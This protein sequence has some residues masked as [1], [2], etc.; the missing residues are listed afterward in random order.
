MSVWVSSSKDVLAHVADREWVGV[1]GLRHMAAGQTP[2][3]EH[4]ADIEAWNQARYDVRR[5]QPWEE[6]WVDLRRAR[7]GA[8][9]SRSRGHWLM[10]N[11]GPS[12]CRA[13]VSFTSCRSVASNGT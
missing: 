12:C 5:D 10:A 8:R 7:R 6:V 11:G 13:F 4:I 9:A 1:K 2:Q 3:V